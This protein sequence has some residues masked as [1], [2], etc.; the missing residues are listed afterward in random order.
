[1]TVITHERWGFRPAC[2]HKK[3]V[4]EACILITTLISELSFIFLLLDQSPNQ[5]KMVKKPT[6]AR[7]NHSAHLS[8][9]LSLSSK[10]LLTS[11]FS[12]SRFRLSLFASTILGLD[13]HRLRIHD[14]STNKL[15]CETTLGNGIAINSLTWGTISPLV[16]EEEKKNRKKRK[17]NKG[18]GVSEAPTVIIAATTN[19]SSVLLYSPTEGR[20]LAALEGGHLG[21]V[22]QFVFSDGK[23]Q[24]KRGWS[25][26]ADGKLIEWDLRR[27]VAIRYAHCPAP[28]KDA[29]TLQTVLS[30]ITNCYLSR[31]LYTPWPISK[32]FRP[33]SLH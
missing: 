21:E 3:K 9:K 1:M 32:P 13:A 8:S 4:R 17:R 16:E 22:K 23:A 15:C 20:T 26:G 2:P 24:G 19:V 7:A 5:N 14:F 11:A 10:T 18:E 27:K 31:Y 30:S 28:P 12:P 29:C 6:K 25:A 33:V